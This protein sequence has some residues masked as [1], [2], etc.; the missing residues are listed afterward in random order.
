MEHSKLPHS[1]LPWRATEGSESPGVR[2][3]GG[4]ICFLK[5]RPFHYHGQD[6]R[7]EQELREWQG[8]LDFIVTACNEHDTLQAKAKLLDEAISVIE[9]L[10]E[11]GLNP[12]TGFQLE[13]CRIASKFL[14]KAEALK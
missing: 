14:K 4:F 8:N 13:K 1:K 2:N 5:G 7:Y 10:D 3:D 6:E 9:M 12:I 11:A